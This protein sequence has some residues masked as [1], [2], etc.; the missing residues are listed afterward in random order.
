[1]VVPKSLRRDM[2][3]R[4]HYAHM[5][6]VSNLSLARE[7]I[8]WLGMSSKISRQRKTFWH[9]TSSPTYP[10]SNGKVEAAVHLAKTAMRKS[11][12]Q[13]QI[14]I[15]PSLN[16]ETRLVREWAPLQCSC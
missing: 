16:T 2:L 4:L 14:H 7:G 13:E 10:Q 3:Y 9:V 6:V 1:M 15:S 12:R 8:Y 11:R 5:G